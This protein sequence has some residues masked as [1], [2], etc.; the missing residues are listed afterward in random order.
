MYLDTLIKFGFN[1]EPQKLKYRTGNDTFTYKNVV[2][3]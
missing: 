2:Y 1:V 3:P